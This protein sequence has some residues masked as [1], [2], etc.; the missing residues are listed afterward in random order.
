MSTNGEQ[1][2]KEIIRIHRC[3]EDAYAANQGNSRF[4]F[5]TRISLRSFCRSTDRFLSLHN[6][7][8]PVFT[9]GGKYLSRL[10]SDQSKCNDG[11]TLVWLTSLD[12][13]SGRQSGTVSGWQSITCFTYVTSNPDL[14]KTSAD[15]IVLLIV[16]GPVNKSGVSDDNQMGDVDV[17][18]TT[19]PNKVEQMQSLTQLILSLDMEQWETLVDVFHIQ[20]AMIHYWI[21][22]LLVQY[23]TLFSSSYCLFYF[24]IYPTEQILLTSCNTNQE[25]SNS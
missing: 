17:S 14:E 15:S 13:V 7:S 2:S 12:L 10:V 22:A 9:F 11:K 5:N 6:S 18:S 25:W 1:T 21:F 19:K 24:H 4:S 16:L 3:L 23:R 8:N 20:K